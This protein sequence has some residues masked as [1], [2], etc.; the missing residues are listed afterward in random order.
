[1]NE[2][3]YSTALLLGEVNF[4]F[5]KKVHQQIV[6]Q[7][8]NLTTEQFGVLYILSKRKDTI[9]SDLAE[10]AGKDKS[11]VMRHLDALEEKNLVVRVNDNSDRRRKI[12][13]IT[14][15]G[16]QMLDKAMQVLNE[17]F[18]EIT[19]SIPEEKMNI[20]REVLLTIK[21]STDCKKIHADS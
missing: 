20:F 8:I 3:Q 2:T 14:K 15:A 16:Q 9:Q 12:L 6:E 19:Q 7:D 4:K 17:V 18:Q 13:V 21:Q 1:M 11:A 5:C 10:F